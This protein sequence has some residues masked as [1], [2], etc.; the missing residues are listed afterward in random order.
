[1]TRILWR[2]FQ[3]WNKIKWHRFLSVDV[4][5]V[6][7]IL[8][9]CFWEITMLLLDQVQFNIIAF[10]ILFCPFARLSCLIHALIV[11]TTKSDLLE[12]NQFMWRYN[13]FVIRA[14]KLHMH[15]QQN[16]FELVWYCCVLWLQVHLC[17]VSLISMFT[18]NIHKYQ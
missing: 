18:Q 4:A 9:K 2:I 15:V 7:K 5:W 11:I 8:Y 1:M 10:S 3:V 6:S 16:L 13:R 17:R 14:L 12:E